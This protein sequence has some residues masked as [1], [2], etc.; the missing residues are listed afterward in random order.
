MQEGKKY[1]HIIYS[2]NLVV[3]HFGNL[4]SFHSW[5]KYL[6]QYSGQNTQGSAF[7]GSIFISLCPH[8]SPQHSHH[9][10]ELVLQYYEH[11]VLYIS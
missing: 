4:G 7:L 5:S 3:P 8:L 10:S 1:I 9:I 6:I 2:Y 11:L